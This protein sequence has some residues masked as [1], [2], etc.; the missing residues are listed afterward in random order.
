MSV[1]ISG[2]SGSGKTT[3]LLQ[4]AADAGVGALLTSPNEYAFERLRAA[5]PANV[6]AMSPA[7][8]ALTILREHRTAH[9]VPGDLE[10]I[11]D[12]RAAVLFEE[13]ATPLL[14]LEWTEV[15]AAEID[16]E[17]PGLRAPH[18]FLQSAF[19][20]IRK[21]RDSLISPEQFLRTALTGATQFY[22]KPPNFA[23][24]ELLQYTKEQYRD[25]LDVSPAELQRQYAREIDL[26]KVI[27]K[28]YSS[29]MEHLVARGCLTAHDVIAEAAL[30]IA[31]DPSTAV[32]FR[33]RFQQLFVDD[34]QE[35]TLAEQTLLARIYG[36]QFEGVTL[37]V[38]QASTI[39]T[40]AGARP[41]KLMALRG[42]RIELTQQHRCAAAIENAARHLV[43]EPPQAPANEPSIALFRASTKRAESQF[44]AEYVIDRLQKGAAPRDIAL[45]FRSV[46]NA[47]VYEE[48]LLERNVPSICVGDVNLFRQPVALDA[49]ALLWNTYDPYR[50][51]YLL[52]TLAAPAL[53]LSDASVYTL[54]SDSPD[55][56]SSLFNDEETAAP[57]RANGR[58][59]L[60]RDVRLAWNVTRGDR[61]ADLSN[62][63]RERLQRFRALRGAWVEA[64]KHLTLPE[65]AVRIWS[66]GLA[67]LAPGSPARG[68]HQQRI[69]SRLYDSICAFAAT[70]S[71]ANLGDFLRA[72][73]A[74]GASD[75]EP[76]ES[77][78]AQGMVR[79][80]SIDAA[81]G[82]SI[83]HVVLPG[84][85][86]GAFPL[87][88]VPDSFLY[89]PSLGMIAKENV[90]E[91]KTSRTAKFSYYMYR[92]KTRELYNREERRAFVYAMR[93]ARR[94]LLVTACERATKGLSAPEFLSELQASRI[95]GIVDVSDRWRPK[96]SVYLSDEA[97]LL[98]L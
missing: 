35:L 32:A 15:M 72:A 48:A 1:I 66:E 76:A 78:H 63:A 7:E 45:L 79:L 19:R 97:E 38:D 59:D 69:L 39:S 30:R 64:M 26:A 85:R 14:K 65:L 6:T 88:Y 90:G 84:A 51:D 24:A 91:A 4:R 62:V 70:H 11:D 95:P 10:I 77:K 41:D 22:A 50:H 13:L 89:S 42:E 31:E 71:P 40:F 34:A 12:V 16:P 55:A 44:V 52:R 8:I 61:D 29:Y 25:S 60:K 21:L 56:Q 67:S 5:A 47:R 82:E 2:P 87:W 18:R 28:L 33:E 23:H 36:D 43:G 94:T 74:R 81:Y 96:N 93:R 86:A 68:M 46:S 58:W 73:E 9:A 27:A 17:I 75:F 49:L 57:P 53:A 83:D 54:C 92:A 37:A 98:S 20:L 80:M 3:L